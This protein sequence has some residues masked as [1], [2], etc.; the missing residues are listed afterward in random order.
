MKNNKKHNNI[1]KKAFKS[2]LIL[3]IASILLYSFALCTMVI[4][5]EIL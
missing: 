3:V 5:P 1:E 2:L 4:F